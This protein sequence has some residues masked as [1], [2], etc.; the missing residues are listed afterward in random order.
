MPDLDHQQCFALYN[1]MVFSG[2][3]ASRQ[4]RPLAKAKHDTKVFLFNIR[5][6]KLSSAYCRM[7]VSTIGIGFGTAEGLGSRV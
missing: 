4:L 7:V 6:L 5:P 1:P 2:I 3:P